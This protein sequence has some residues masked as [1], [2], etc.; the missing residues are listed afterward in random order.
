MGPVDLSSAETVID[1]TRRP[2]AGSDKARPAPFAQ[3]SREALDDGLARCISQIGAAIKNLDHV[4]LGA[5][6]RASTLRQ[7]QY[8]PAFSAQRRMGD[9]QDVCSPWR[10]HRQPCQD[11]DALA[12]PR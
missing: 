11:Q 6:V 7:G 2:P 9:A 8:T 12:R 4:L 5:P 1:R 10:A 3:G